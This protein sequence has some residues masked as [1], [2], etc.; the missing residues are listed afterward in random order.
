MNFGDGGK[1]HP[2][3]LITREE[4]KERMIFSSV[5]KIHITAPNTNIPKLL[6]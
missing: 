2:W 3:E 5:P 4:I 1:N 6:L